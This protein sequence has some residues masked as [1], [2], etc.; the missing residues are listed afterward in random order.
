MVVRLRHSLVD[1]VPELASGSG[2]IVKIYFNVPS[3]VSA[4]D[5]S[6]LT[7]SGYNS[8]SAQFAGSVLDYSPELLSGDV[9]VISCCDKRGDIDNLGGPVSV[10]ISDLTYL[11][12]FFFTLGQKPPCYDEADLDGD[13]SVQITDLNYLVDFLF[14]DGPSPVA[15]P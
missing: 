9:T 1:A 2:D 15:C 14:R 7:M 13:G 10:D 8:Y 6:S 4:G 3:N 5:V 12:R 11:V